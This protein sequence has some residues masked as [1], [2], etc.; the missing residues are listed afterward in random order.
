MIIIGGRDARTDVG[1]PFR[2]LDGLQYLLVTLR[3]IR[4]HMVVV[5]RLPM[6][7]V[8]GGCCPTHQHGIRN[9]PL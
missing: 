9:H 5:E 1:P 7:G 4:K 6:A 8:Q 3:Q 2:G